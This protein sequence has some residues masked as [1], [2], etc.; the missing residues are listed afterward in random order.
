MEIIDAAIID[1]RA[2]EPLMQERFDA[3]VEQMSSPFG[4]EYPECG[5]LLFYRMTAM[6]ELGPLEAVS[7]PVLYVAFLVAPYVRHKVSEWIDDL[8]GCEYP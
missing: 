1:P 2:L 7:P 3:G 5:Y 8:D 4:I 6:K